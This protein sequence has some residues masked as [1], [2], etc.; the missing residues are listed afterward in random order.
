M[1]KVTIE[2][3]ASNDAFKETS[4]N[5]EFARILRGMA[6]KLEMGINSRKLMDINGN[7]VGSVEYE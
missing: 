7:K 5:E 2:I 6:D 1:E 3:N 4:E